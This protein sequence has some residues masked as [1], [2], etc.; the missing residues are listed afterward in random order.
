VSGQRY[1]LLHYP[2]DV[3]AGARPG[4]VLGCDELGRPYEVLDAEYDSATDRTSVHLQY[5]SPDNVRA[6]LTQLAAANP[7]NHAGSVR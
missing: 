3:T 7:A 2:G 6:H 4:M 5:A 1:G